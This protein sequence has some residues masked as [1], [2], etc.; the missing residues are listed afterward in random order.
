[1][2]VRKLT[3][4]LIMALTMFGAVT[5][6]LGGITQLTQAQE[7]FPAADPF[8]FDPDFHWFEPIYDADL[9]DMKPQK[10]ANSGWFATYDRL[11]LYASR[12]ELDD[13]QASETKLDGGWGNRYEIGYMLPQEDTGWLFSFTELNGPNAGNNIERERLNRFN[14]QNLGTG[15]GGGGG[16]QPIDPRF[17]GDGRFTIPP[18][19]RNV[20]GFFRRFVIEEDSLNKMDFDSY[21]LNKTWRMEPYHYGGILEPMVGFRWIRMTDYNRKDNF[22]TTQDLNNPLVF[23]GAAEEYVISQNIT[24]NEVLLGQVGFRYTKFRDRFTFASEFR[25]FTG[26][27]LQCST[28]RRDT[29]TTVYNFTANTVTIGA[30]PL[31]TFNESLTPQY[32]RN[33]EFVIGFDVRGELNYQLTKMIT[34]RGGFQ[35]IDLA[36]GIW[37]GGDANGLNGLTVGGGDRDQDLVMVGGT[38]GVTLNR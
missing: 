23:A 10:R 14:S 16:A 3:K 38:F 31:A 36:T 4:S 37:R 17:P 13:T 6:T 34:V 21:E 15:G 5:H 11:N 32:T 29:E 2:S 1:M 22:S 25:A 7:Y 26:G 35:V 27:N 30:P 28:A 24:D 18:Q 19:D 8:A 33:E 12:P 9:A 20:I